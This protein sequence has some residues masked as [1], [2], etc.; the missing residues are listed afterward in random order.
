M[1][2]FIKYSI[3][4]LY[5]VFCD[6]FKVGRVL[7]AGRRV[8]EKRENRMLERRLLNA[9]VSK[10]KEMRKFM[11]DGIQNEDMDDDELADMILN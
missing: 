2:Y 5:E 11:M 9:R 10:R 6:F 7:L 8:D 3:V 1:I 4:N